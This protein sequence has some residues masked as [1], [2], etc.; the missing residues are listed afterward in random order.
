MGRGWEHFMDE[1][2]L[3]IQPDDQA[4]NHEYDSIAQW[5]EG[6]EAEAKRHSRFRW[7]GRKDLPDNPWSRRVRKDDSWIPAQESLPGGEQ[8]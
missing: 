6:L 8:T 5:L 3:L 7:G 4:H 1:G 2:A